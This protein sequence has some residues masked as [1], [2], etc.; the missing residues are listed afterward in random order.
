MGPY[1]GTQ[2]R[3]LPN[4]ELD[5]V[6][7]CSELFFLSVL[8]SCS[9]FHAPV[10]RFT[11]TENVMLIPVHVWNGH[12]RTVWNLSIDELV[13]RRDGNGISANNSRT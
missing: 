1:N 9:S 5:P 11:Y 2:I 12:L 3:S 13:S 6:D 4:K 7:F 10:A 8:R